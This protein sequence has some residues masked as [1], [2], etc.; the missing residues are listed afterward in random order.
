MELPCQLVEFL[1]RPVRQGVPHARRRHLADPGGGLPAAY[2]GGLG[3]PPAVLTLASPV[4]GTVI[5]M[6][7]L[8]EG[9]RGGLAGAALAAVS[10][11]VAGRGD[12]LLTRTTTVEVARGIPAPA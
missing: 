6:T 10:A 8:G 9:I 2:A 12:I 1:R 5:G 4:A 7:L 11:L 3:A